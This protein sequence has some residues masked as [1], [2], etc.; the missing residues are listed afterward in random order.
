MSTEIIQTKTLNKSIIK[1]CHAC[2]EIIESF[3]EVEKCPRC[4][5]SFLPCQYFGKVHAKNTSE[6]KQL[7]S[8]VSELQEETLIKGLYIIW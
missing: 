1:K 2:G 5:K 3:H 8:H 7:F 4:K 6:F